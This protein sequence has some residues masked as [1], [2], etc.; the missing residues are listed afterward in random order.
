MR[1]A[2][3][4]L[5]VA[6][7]SAVALPAAAADG[8]IWQPCDSLHAQFTTV[9]QHHDGFTAPYEGDNSLSDR[10][11]SRTSFTS[12]I[13]CAASLWRGASVVIDP[14]VAAGAG[15]DGVTGFAG[16]SNGEIARVSTQRPRLYRARSY[17]Q[18]SFALSDE[19]ETVES[20]SNV[21]A[22]PQAKDRIVISAGTLSVLDFFDA[23]AY[24]HD[25][26]T[27]LL[28]WALFANGA[29]DFPAD[30]RGYTV[31][32]VAEVITPDFAV[33]AGHFAMPKEANGKPLNL[34]LGKFYGD[35]FEVEQGFSLFDQPGR[36]RGMLWRN[37][38]DMG[39][40][41]LAIAA[42]GAN[43]PD[44]TRVRAPRDKKGWGLNWEQAISATLGGFARVGANDGRNETFAFTEI[45]RHASAGLALQGAAWGRKQDAVELAFAVNGL[46]HDHRD[47]LAAGGYGFIIG[48]GR[49]NY[50]TER[51]I[52]LQYQWHFTRH[53]TLTPDWQHFDNPAYNRDRG[54]VEV[55]SLRLHG[56]I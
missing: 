45:D 15:F 7:L 34:Q 22:G 12:T 30:A 3:L 5:P 37:R 26:R 40:Y 31:G 55:Y 32:A 24:A 21:I 49:L 53:W 10:S 8:G 33:R 19:T 16:F 42:A 20:S 54:P 47:Y 14:E 43:A 11:T 2:R 46:S 27:Q 38:A 23:N 52:E 18:Q 1:L 6:A 17:L 35:A 56:E 4:L 9:P 44:I 50:G 36:L 51:I 25:P 29:W 48:D 28:N 39:N 41:A 13:Y